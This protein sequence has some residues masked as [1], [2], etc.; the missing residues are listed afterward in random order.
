MY[1]EC[2]KLMDAK[3]LEIDEFGRIAQCDV[4]EDSH[5]IKKAKTDNPEFKKKYLQQTVDGKP[6]KTIDEIYEAAEKARPLY[7]KKMRRIV[8][9]IEEWSEK[10]DKKNRTIQTERSMREE[11]EEGLCENK[12]RDSTMCFTC[13]CCYLI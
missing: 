13:W 4:H 12:G 8:K 9:K 6:V 1:L 5:G 11:E 2:R 7:K 3:Y 10:E